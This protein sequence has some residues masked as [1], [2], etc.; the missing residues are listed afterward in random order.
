MN[1][2]KNIYDIKDNELFIKTLEKEHGLPAKSNG[3]TYI[4]QAGKR[5]LIKIGETSED[6]RDYCEK[7]IQPRC[8]KILKIKDELIIKG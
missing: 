3:Y 2:E 5:G 8:P 4:I 7:V 6:V 1:E